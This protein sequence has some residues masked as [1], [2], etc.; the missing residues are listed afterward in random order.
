[1]TKAFN[2]TKKS[3][4]IKIE[5]DA[6]MG[7]LNNLFRGSGKQKDAPPA[8]PKGWAAPVNGCLECPDEISKQ[9]ARTLSEYLSKD[10]GVTRMKLGGVCGK[11]ETDAVRIIGYALSRS[12][13]GSLDIDLRNVSYHEAYS[14]IESIKGSKVSSLRFNANRETSV[15]GNLYKK[16]ANVLPETNVS[17]LSLSCCY[18]D[19]KDVSPLLKNLPPN[20]KTLDLCMNKSGHGI[21]AGVGD[22]SL[23]LLLPQIKGSA[24][25]KLS[26]S[27]TDVT[28]KHIPA[29]I[30]I[31]NDPETRLSSVSLHDSC[32]SEEMRLESG[33]ACRLKRAPALAAQYK[34]E[35]PQELL[36]GELPSLT[37]IREG[38]LF[39]QIAKAGRL[40]ELM[41]RQIRCNDP[42][43]AADL[44][45]RQGDMP[46]ALAF[47]RRLGGYGEIFRPELWT[48]VKE[49]QKAW[50][51]LSMPS[52]KIF[53]DG[54]NG[55]PSFISVKNKVSAN[56]VKNL[57]KT[58]ER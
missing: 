32:V 30:K 27:D 55:R 25:E 3:F 10:A 17:E 33:L 4:I 38:K 35:V 5:K 23:E 20:I 16:L 54:K 1:M 37:E 51:F 12:S 18:L 15:L 34:R 7:F 8:L 19:D 42:V 22:P 41:T 2:P 36:S 26:L 14:F 47:V 44:T 50:N 43:N 58:K 52:D 28:D 57:L 46:P 29:L 39:S 13:I 31:I 21:M 6:Y 24:L 49:M 48:N 45:G 11:F 40:P 53:M 56:A 9:D